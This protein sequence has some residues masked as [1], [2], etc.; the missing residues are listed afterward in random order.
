MQSTGYVF[1]TDLAYR[2]V[3]AG[4]RV[5]EVPI[6]FVERV[7]GDSKM[8]GPVAARVAAPH[9]P[10]GAARASYAA[11]PRAAGTAHP[12]RRV[13]IPGWLLLVAFVVVPLVEI[14]VLIQVG[15]VIGPWWT[16]LLLIGASVLGT[17]L[18]RREGSRSWAALQRRAADRAGC[19]PA[20][21]PTPR[22]SSSAAPSCSRRASS[23]TSS[24]S[25]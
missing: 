24:A 19:P 7:R 6:E 12:M 8:S 4:L 18:I 23:A 1:Q 21:S 22:S 13:R 15:Q 3:R 9:H 16:I 14:F 20:S 17:W 11:R 5:V 10:L 25:C 2:A